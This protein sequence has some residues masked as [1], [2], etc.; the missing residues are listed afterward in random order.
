[1]KERDRPCN[2]P[3][4]INVPAAIELKIGSAK[5][6]VLSDLLRY[7]PNKIPSGVIKQ[8]TTYNKRLALK[9]KPL[10]LICK[11][12][13]KL[14]AHLCANIAIKIMSMTD[15]L[16]VNPR[17]EPAMIECIDNMINAT[18]ANCF[19]FSPACSLI[20]RPICSSAKNN[21]KTPP[22]MRLAKGYSKPL[23]TKSAVPSA[24]K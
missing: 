11:E 17:A 2:V 1:M 14:A 16:S 7:V 19:V 10:L 9:E 22:A 3:R 24:N 5:E 8:N 21:R 4:Y 6:C 23:F 12:S 15:R 18:K 13:A 20:S